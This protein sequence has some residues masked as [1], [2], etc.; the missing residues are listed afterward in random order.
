MNSTL[1][2][3]RFT[4]AGLE[5]AWQ[6]L[7]EAAASDRTPG[8]TAVV[9]SSRGASEPRW[10]GRQQ[11]APDS[12][13]LREDALFLIASPTKP[14]VALAVMMLVEEGRVQ[15]ADPVSTYVPEFNSNGKRNITLLHC[16]THTS[17]LP[18]MLPDNARLRGAQAPL[19]E[20]LARACELKPDFLPGFDV[21]YQSLGYLML[22]EVV[23]RVTGRGV[24]EMLAERVFAPLGMH[25]TSLGLDGGYERVPEIRVTGVQLSG[26]SYWNEPYWRRL[27]VPWGGVFS[28][29][30]DLAKLCRH[31]LGIHRGHPGIVSRSTLTTMTANWF[32]RM[33]DVPE[34]HR[35]CFPWGLGWQLHWPAHATTFGDLL[36]AEA[37]GHWGSTGVM[38]W[39]D[40]ALDAFAVALSTEPL[41]L[42]RRWLA[43]FTSTVCAAI[44]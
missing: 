32:E 18:D 23:R 36:S 3:D 26:A 4:S 16:L 30:V 13:P 40:P 10:F 41:E 1:V 28:D 22:G 38:L 21:Q 2:A 42:G 37:Y 12:G 25:N 31:L 27:G 6:F 19:S 14:I 24:G 20:F 43:R 44:A 17:G 7:A 29:A 9:G 33:P 5:R 34:R 11:V 15:L 35:R 8:V 39:I